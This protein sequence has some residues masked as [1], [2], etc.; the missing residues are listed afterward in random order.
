MV[1]IRSFP[2]GMAYFQGRLLLV[3]GSVAGLCWGRKKNTPENARMSPPKN[4]FKRTF[5]LP[6]MASRDM[7]VFGRV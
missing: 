1:G 6:L 2:F 5:H 3:S 7:L 4:N